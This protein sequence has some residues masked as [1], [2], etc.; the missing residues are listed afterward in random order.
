M[1]SGLQGGGLNLGVSIPSSG[2]KCE[3]VVTAKSRKPRL[4][5]SRLS[6]SGGLVARECG[7]LGH[8]FPPGQVASLVEF[9]QIISSTLCLSLLVCDL[10]MR[11]PA[12]LVPR[13]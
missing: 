7:W 11:I 6:S 12:F 5:G 8:L 13:G 10:G 1:V 4:L 9:G 2:G 3:V